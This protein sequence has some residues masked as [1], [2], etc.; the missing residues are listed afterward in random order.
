MD[1]KYIDVLNIQIVFWIWLAFMTIQMH[2]GV[3]VS[4]LLFYMLLTFSL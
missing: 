4:T 3:I 2:V 1:C